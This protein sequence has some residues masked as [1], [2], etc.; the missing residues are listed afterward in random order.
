MADRIDWNFGSDGTNDTTD[1]IKPIV[2][3]VQ[4]HETVCTQC[5]RSTDS[6]GIFCQWCGNQ[7]NP[8]N[9]LERDRS[10]SRPSVTAPAAPDNRQSP[11][12]PEPD[13]ELR[14]AFVTTAI[15]VMFAVGIAAFTF[16]FSESSTVNVITNITITEKYPAHT[17]QDWCSNAPCTSSDLG[18]VIDENGNWYSV[19][20]AQLWGMLNVNETYQVRYYY[21]KY[22]TGSEKFID[23]AVINGTTYTVTIGG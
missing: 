2:S 19:T 10:E 16:W 17:Y 18:R 23:G 21:S 14:N 6:S 4:L 9:H 12:T 22:T 1:A 7:L 8:H 13:H 15:V 3:D 11:R 5:G 20:N